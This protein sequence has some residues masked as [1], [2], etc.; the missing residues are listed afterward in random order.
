MIIDKEED[1]T[2]GKEILNKMAYDAMDII[3]QG[4][5]DLIEKYENS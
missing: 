4:Q 5:I 1:L 3:I 2:K